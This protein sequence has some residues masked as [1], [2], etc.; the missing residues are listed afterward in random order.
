MGY[1]KSVRVNVNL[2]PK[3][4][5][6]VAEEA[7]TRQVSTSRCVEDYVQKESEGGDND[8]LVYSLEDLRKD[9]EEADADYKAGK[10]K[11]YDTAEEM[12]E[13]LDKELKYEEYRLHASIP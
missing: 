4:Y 8:G 9:I 2:R 13:A 12:F 10:M 7:E 11:F 3:L 5:Q 1:M 6:K